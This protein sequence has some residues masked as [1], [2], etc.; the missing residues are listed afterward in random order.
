MRLECQGMRRHISIP[1]LPHISSHMC[2]SSSPSVVPVPSASSRRARCQR[3]CSASYEMPR[4]AHSAACR[5]DVQ[6]SRPSVRSF[7]FHPRAH[8]A[9]ALLHD[10]GFFTR[11]LPG[12]SS[13]AR[14][15]PSH[16]AASPPPASGLRRFARR[17]H[18]PL[19]HTP[20]GKSYSRPGPSQKSGRNDV[21]GYLKRS[22][23]KE[24][25]A[26]IT[27]TRRNKQ[28]SAELVAFRKIWKA[29]MGARPAISRSLKYQSSS[30]S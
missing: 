22:A 1:T 26:E 19:R 4:M 8:S 6:Q 7:P 28:H 17:R 18:T 27:K 23:K 9:H 5:R 10:L 16:Q 24:Q 13:P 30:R 29:L 21:A 20:A 25:T 2:R 14:L 3:A 12:V 15:D 11:V